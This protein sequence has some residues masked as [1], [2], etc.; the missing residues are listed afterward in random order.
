[1]IF[2]RLS[3]CIFGFAVSLSLIGCDHNHHDKIFSPTGET[4]LLIADT[5]RKA[6]SG[7]NVTL[8]A[9]TSEW[10]DGLNFEWK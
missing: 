3:S 6:F 10:G 7:Q 1:M 4:E 9:F 2:N 8:H 5:E